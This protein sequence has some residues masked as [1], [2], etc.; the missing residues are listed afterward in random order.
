MIDKSKLLIELM[1]QSINF[2]ID[3]KKQKIHSRHVIAY[4][5]ETDF[6]YI[7]YMCSEVCSQLKAGKRLNEV[8]ANRLL[9]FKSFN[10]I[11]ADLYE[12]FFLDAPHE[13]VSYFLNCLCISQI[14][15]NTI[16]E[17]LVSP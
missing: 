4:R 12:K 7:S 15:L 9:Y 11:D 8:D 10:F 5:D 13:D 1:E 14:L 2:F 3:Y 6:D 16:R 17:G